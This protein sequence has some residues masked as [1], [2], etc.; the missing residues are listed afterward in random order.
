MS[1]RREI[2]LFIEEEL[3]IDFVNA[4]AL[5]HLLQLQSVGGGPAPQ[6][7]R[8]IPHTLPKIKG[9]SKD[10][11][12]SIRRAK[13]WGTLPSI[14]AGRQKSRSGGQLWLFL[15]VWW[16]QLTNN[17]WSFLYSFL[18]FPHFHSL[19]LRFLMMLFKVTSKKILNPLR[20]KCAVINCFCHAMLRV[21]KYIS[22]YFKTYCYIIR[23]FGVHLYGNNDM[24]SNSNKINIALQMFVF[25]LYYC[26]FF[27]AYLQ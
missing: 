16:A 2:F 6:A 4:P 9:S 3:K 24:C 15:P 20:V 26:F 27:T 17:L 21:W 22:L 7:C 5:P 25:F 12:L 19:D 18:H 13:N 10:H 14:K 11:P 1:P 8:S 23:V